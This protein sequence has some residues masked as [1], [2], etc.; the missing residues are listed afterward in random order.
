MSWHLWLYKKIFA[1]PTPQVVE[2]EKIVYKIIEVQ[3][4]RTPARWSK[5][6]KEAVAS[7]SF[8]PGFR[9]L[10]E[11][12]GLHKAVIEDKLKHQSQDDVKAYHQLQAG[13]FWLEWDAMQV[14]RAGVVLNKPPEQ[15]AY[16]SELEAFKQIDAKIERVGME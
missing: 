13:I 4:P 7:L 2:V 9:A 14:Q 8:H 11:L 5:E 1:P 10:Q 3:S 12:R 16:E 6:T 15:D